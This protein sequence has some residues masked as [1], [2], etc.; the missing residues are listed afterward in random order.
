MTMSKPSLIIVSEIDQPEREQLSLLPADIQEIIPHTVSYLKPQ[1]DLSDAFPK[2]PV[3]LS[4]RHSIQALR[5]YSD[6]EL[7]E[8]RR[9]DC[10][11]VGELTA[12]KAT[13][14][15]FNV[16]K[17]FPR[18]ELLVKYL[19]DNRQYQFVHLGGDKSVPGIDEVL[20]RAGVIRMPITMYITR[21]LYPSADINSDAILFLSPSGA[22]S[23]L[24]HNRIPAHTHV[25]AI[26]P[27]TAE[28]L[29]AFGVHPSL[30][31]SRPSLLTLARETI[32]FLT[33][34]T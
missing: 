12:Q 20:R 25:T 24:R 8:V 2:V 13:D 11:V 33:A 5:A 3:V 27:T 23:V 6:A 34:R 17:Y 22:M 30:V 7:A 19:A 15:G 4:S 9:R 10:F 21:L 14:I 32:D 29:R 28:T 1:L 18:L 16:E 26:G 31:A